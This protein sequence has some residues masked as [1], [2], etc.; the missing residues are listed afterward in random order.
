MRAPSV[1]ANPALAVAAALLGALGCRGEAAPVAPPE[2]RIV[3]RGFT[4]ATAVR[5][6][7]ATAG[8]L[9]VVTDRGLD[10]WALGPGTARRAAAAPTEM[11]GPIVGHAFDAAR[12]ALWVATEAKLVRIDAAAGP[13]R[14]LVPPPELGLASL[15]GAS[16]APSGDGGAFV[17]LERGLFRVDPDGGWRATEVTAPV[18]AAL[19]SGGQVWIGSADGIALASAGAPPRWLG[20]AQGCDVAQVRELVRSPDGRVLALGAGP[21]GGDR[22]AL[23]DATGC[24]TYRIS[25]ARPWRDVATRGGELLILADR[26]LYA[27]GPPPPRGRR[28]A[29]DGLRLIPVPR[30]D[31]RPPRP[32]PFVLRPIDVAVPVGARAVAAAEGELFL[33]TEHLG[34]ARAGGGRR[35]AWLRPGELGD[36]A[37]GMSVACEARDACWLATGGTRAWRFDGQGFAAMPVDGRRVVALAWDAATGLVALLADGDA[38][39]AAAWT[40]DA[41]RELGDS[42]ALDGE[43]GV[44]FVVPGARG[45]RWIGLTAAPDPAA[46]PR[47]LAVIGPGA[48]SRWI[49]VELDGVG[50]GRLAAARDAAQVGGTTWILTDAGLERL[51]ARVGRLDGPPGVRVDAIAAAGEV[52]YA[53]AGDALWSRGADGWRARGRLGATIRDLAG[54]P[55]GRLWIATDRGVVRFDGGRT[56]RVDHRRGLLDDRVLELAVDPYG[57]VWA[58]GAQGVT[59]VEP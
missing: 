1:P 5:A 31:G 16:V 3:V 40:G 57:R 11:D 37:R 23:V 7:Y 48:A 21:T 45:E 41:W 27:L 36:G 28:L 34:I 46:S 42:R 53:A 20:P 8:A 49:D 43:P 51:G 6:L 19:A 58:R 52:L 12:G 44:A 30:A 15:A 47:A 25:P 35:S 18:T 38:L 9:L 17:G 22:V 14:E 59:L 13:A 2:A 55:D 56:R 29:R 4:E 10:R 26:T 32:S 54:A 50:P 24:D 39:V 33:G